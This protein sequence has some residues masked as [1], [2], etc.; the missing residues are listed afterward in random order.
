MYDRAKA[1]L[2]LVIVALLIGVPA[3]MRSEGFQQYPNMP[4]ARVGHSA[5][6]LPNGQVLIVG[7]VADGSDGKSAILFSP[8]SYWSTTSPAN[9]AR[10]HHTATEISPARI[11]VVGGSDPSTFTGSATAEIYSVNTTTWSFT[12]SMNEPRQFH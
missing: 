1:N 2:A 11:L 12:G 7:G 5:T 8:T 4:Q 10:W 6:L 9:E 3:L